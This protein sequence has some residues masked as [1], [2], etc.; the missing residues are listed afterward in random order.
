MAPA[1][2]FPA[3]NSIGIEHNFGLS[4]KLPMTMQMV[5]SQTLHKKGNH[6]PLKGTETE[7]PSTQ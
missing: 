5:N 4:F 7:E 6:I 3:T 1:S 2:F